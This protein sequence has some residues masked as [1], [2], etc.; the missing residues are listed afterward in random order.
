MGRKQKYL[1]V[2]ILFAAVL[3]LAVGLPFILGNGGQAQPE[4]VVYTPRPTSPPVRE[5]AAEIKGVIE[6]EAG[7][8]AAERNCTYPMHYWQAKPEKW[9]NEVV[10]SGQ[11]YSRESIRDLYMVDDPDLQTRLIQ[12]MYTSFLNIL[13]GADMIA[14]ESTLF[15]AAEWLEHNPPGSELSEFNVRQGRD[16]TQVLEHF[17]NG[18]I[19]PGACP[20]A[21]PAP[22]PTLEPTETATPVP[23]DPPPTAAPQVQVRPVQPPAAAPA[24]AQ[25]APPPTNPP[26]P[27]PPTNPPLPSPTDPIPTEPPP[28]TSTQ[29][30]PTE[31][32]LPTATPLPPPTSTPPSNEPLKQHPQGIALSE[33]YNVP[34]QEIMDWHSQGF[35]FGDIDKAYDLSQQTGTAV[36]TILEL[37]ASGM[38][39]GE[40]RDALNP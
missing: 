36:S 15:N 40:I 33:K 12:Q 38:G 4:T 17:N 25:P 6:N 21:P 31:T 28:P 19:G 10:L 2:S 30:V 11:V 18:A 16:M 32:P 27:P 9:P 22:T 37:L 3:L 35:G 39:W 1:T 13:F 14:V 8:E 20:D 26:P 7:V 29:P 5:N 34:Y 24:P 23:T